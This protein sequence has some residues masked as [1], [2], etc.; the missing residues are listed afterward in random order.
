MLLILISQEFAHIRDRVKWIQIGTGDQAAED[1]CKSHGTSMLSLVVGETVGVSKNADP[2]VVRMPC[3]GLG[4]A[5]QGHE[6]IDGLGMIND[7]LA[8]K[9]SEAGGIAPS[10]VLMSVYWTPKFFPGANSQAD[11]DGFTLRY[12]P[13]LDS[14]AEKGAILITGS[15]NDGTASVTGV[16]AR[17]GKTQDKAEGLRVP[18][19]LVM[20]GIHSDG[21][22]GYKGNFD[23]DAGLPHAYAPGLDVKVADATIPNYV[24]GAQGTS[25]SAAITAG[26]AAYYIRLAQLN[27]I[28]VETSPQAIKDFIVKT[29]WSRQ[30]VDNR[31][32]PGIWNS[33]DVTLPAKEWTP[34]TPDTKRAAAVF[35]REFYA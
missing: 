1:D 29:S 23:Y 16:P 22:S 9:T 17:F 8:K 19:L 35:R 2:I 27:L 24:G 15:G 21:R 28:D 13:L 30:D 6:W 20:G 33:A 32:R 3:R 4:K 25:C 12:K 10:V 26:L 34:R 7:D 11:M 31:P 18:S 5:M 14:L